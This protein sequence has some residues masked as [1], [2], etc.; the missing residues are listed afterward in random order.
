MAEQSSVL[1]WRAI[2]S[3]RT[4]EQSVTASGVSSCLQLVT[5]VDG[6]IAERGGGGESS[7]RASVA[8]R[9]VLRGLWCSMLHSAN[10]LH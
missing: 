6:A 8:C 4:S 5:E 2:D 10:G 9:R 1:Y 3:E 7:K